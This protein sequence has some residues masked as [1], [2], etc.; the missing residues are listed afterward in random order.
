MK[1]GVIRVIAVCVFRQGNAI[2]V[3][4]GRDPTKGETFYRPLGGEVEFGEPSRDAAARE[5]REEIGAEVRDAR[6]LGAI[7]SIF[8]F[9]GEPGHEIMIVYE[10]DLEDESLYAREVIEGRE[11]QGEPITARW[12]P[13]EGFERE[14]APPLYPEGLIGL[15]G[16]AG[17]GGGGKR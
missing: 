2:L 14:G 6:F 12:M 10:A 3:E 11:S 5:V 17:A 1:P 7:E 16:S 8:T 13:L 4:E 9:D 15:L